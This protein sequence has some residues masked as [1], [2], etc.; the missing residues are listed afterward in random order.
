MTEPILP[1]DQVMQDITGPVAPGDTMPNQGP[2]VAGE[3]QG[4]PAPAG[5]APTSAQPAPAAPTA[6]TAPDNSSSKWLNVVKGALTGLALGG[7]P[8]AIGGAIDPNRAR[9]AYRQ[10]GEIAQANTNAAKANASFANTRAANAVL[11]AK[12]RQTQLDQLPAD[13]KLRQDELSL[14]TAQM[15]QGA[16][17]YPSVVAP[18]T[19]EG[20]TAAMKG[21]QDAHGAVPELVFLH[22]GDHIVGYDPTVMSGNSAVLNQVNLLQKLNGGPALNPAT[23]KNAPNKTQLT[24]AALDLPH[25]TFPGM[26]KAKG[27]ISRYDG[28]IRSAQMWPEDDP[29][30]ES[31]IDMLKEGRKEL[32]DAYAARLKDQNEQAAIRGQA[33]QNAK[34][35]AV[36]D[37]TTNEV[38]YV[39]AAQAK[40]GGLTP[41]PQG[42]SLMARGAQLDD[43]QAGSQQ[44]RQAITGLKTPF[45]PESL[46]AMTAAV[47]ATDPNIFA[48][49]KDAA[50]QSGLTPDQQDV[51]V[52]ILQLNERALSLRN[53]AGQGQASD[54][55]RSAVANMLPAIKDLSE[56]SKSLA[57]KKLDAFD[58]QVGILRKGIPGVRGVT[59]NAAPAAAPATNDFFSKFGGKA[60]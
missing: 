32:S 33:A 58:N 6:T 7:I 37:P 52:K 46:A 27:L 57:I 40:Q 31:T 15:L 55:L 26:D 22:L 17:I 38:R 43:I 60:R 45:N 1:Q 42:A 28:L 51:A 5:T 25:P 41:G 2:M 56:S 36:V 14:R 9:T 8:G 53:I 35:V 50:L 19:S 20:A 4:V 18:N 10:E 34:A 16:G 12:Y 48:Q 24:Q 23:L 3:V 54:Q 11:D 47:R 13:L 59:S 49:Y 39:S 21:L 30:K 29:Q 44:L